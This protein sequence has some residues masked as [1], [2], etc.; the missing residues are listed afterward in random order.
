MPLVTPFTSNEVAWEEAN[1]LSELTGNPWDGPGSERFFA[2][3]E[4]VGMQR[5][6]MQAY[7][8]KLGK[9]MPE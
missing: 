3:K 5:S 6:V 8:D 1:R 2:H 7:F 9:V 4:T